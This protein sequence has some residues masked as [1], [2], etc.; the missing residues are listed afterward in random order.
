MRTHVFSASLKGWA[1]LLFGGAIWGITFSLAKIATSNG[2]HPL[3]LALW[4]SVF[5]STFAFLYVTC[6]RRR[7]PLDGTH[8]VFYLICGL[9]GTAIPG[10][11]YFYSADQVPAGVLSIIIALVPIMSFAISAL[12][13]LDRLSPLRITGVILGLVAIVMMAAPE[14]SLPEPGLTPWILL[15]VLAS[16]CY[17]TENNYIALKRPG[18][19]DAMTILCGMF[20]MAALV[21]APIVWST[22]TFVPLSSPFG[23]V[24]LCVATMAAINVVSYGMFIHLVTMTGPVF[25]S[26]M[27]YPI[28]ISGVIWGMIIFG[29]QHSVWIWGALVVML[30]G[31]TLVKPMDMDASERAGETP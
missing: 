5:G 2:A 3:G 17:A 21:L 29:E 28:T 30:L 16:A 10:T 31:L 22:G 23:T 9:L 24:E 7:L 14:T 1:I 15:A 13:G 20:M 8:I 26:Q 19:T 12:F 11:L 6:R 25:A 4:Q 18:Q 27:A